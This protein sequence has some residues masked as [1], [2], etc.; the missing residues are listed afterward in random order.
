MVELWQKQDFIKETVNKINAQN[1]IELL[2]L[3]EEAL[4]FDMQNF[5]EYDFANYKNFNI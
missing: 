2:D 5:K 3:K 1:K 4:K